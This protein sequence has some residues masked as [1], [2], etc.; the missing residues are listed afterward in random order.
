M[1]ASLL[2]KALTSSFESCFRLWNTISMVVR[3]AAKSLVSRFD[4]RGFSNIL[5]ITVYRAATKSFSSTLNAYPAPT[6]MIWKQHRRPARTFEMLLFDSSLAGVFL[7]LLN[8]TVKYSR[9]TEIR[10][11]MI[12]KLTYWVNWGRPR[13]TERKWTELLC[14]LRTSK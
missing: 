9:I 5:W 11:Q 10:S 3:N 1:R 14:Y 12:S 4:G 7:L 6:S 8:S 2:T 13:N